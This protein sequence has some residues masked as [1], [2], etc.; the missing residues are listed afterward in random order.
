MSNA[1]EMNQKFPVEGVTFDE[2]SGLTCA[3]IAAGGT[4]AEVFL[5]GAHLARLTRR[6][7]PLLF[8]SEQSA[9]RPGKALRGGVPLI[10]PWFGNHPTNPALPAHGF[11]RTTDWTLEDVRREGEDTVLTF[12][13]V[14]TNETRAIW[15]HEF[16]LDYEIRI[17]EDLILTLRTEN[18]GDSAFQYEEALHTYLAVGDIHQISV[19]GLAGTEYIDK[20]DA[21]QRKRMNEKTLSI[22]GETDSVYVNTTATCVVNDPVL[23]RRLVLEKEG[24]QSTVVWNPWQEKAKAFSDFGDD[25]WRGMVCIETANAAENSITLGPGESHQMSV[26]VREV[27]K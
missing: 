5:Q 26:R 1:K 2:S 11:A 20:T 4:D 17:G 22:T 8:M 25:E 15:P 27:R 24:S 7:E 12:R 3:R 16:L 18:R 9:Y 14:P 6:G 10:F 21:M 13:L 23:R 19:E